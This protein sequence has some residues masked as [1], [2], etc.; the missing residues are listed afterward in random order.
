MLWSLA[1]IAVGKQHDEAIGAQP[2]AFA[3]CNKL[4]DYGLRAIDEIA[5][6]PLPHYQRFWFR[7]RKTIFKT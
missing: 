4:V 3:R 7:A 5:K 6:L 1:F 2:L